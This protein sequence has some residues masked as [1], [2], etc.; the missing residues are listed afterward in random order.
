MR[1]LIWS[2]VLL[3]HATAFAQG[4]KDKKD[5]SVIDGALVAPKL[6]AAKHEFNEN[7]MRGA[8]TLYRE[9]WMSSQKITMRCT[10]LRNVIII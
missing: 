1:I 4:E 6:I 5:A 10:V 3:A 7:N 9:I 2:L 8:L